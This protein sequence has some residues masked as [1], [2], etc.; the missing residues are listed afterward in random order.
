MEQYSRVTRSGQEVRG[1]LVEVV[2][3][4]ALTYTLG[5]SC[6]LGI[7]TYVDGRFNDISR[8]NN[9]EDLVPTIP[10]EDWGFKHPTGEIHITGRIQ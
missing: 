5:D 8:I 7:I 9:K 3:S 2:W 10:L 6:K 1:E 4:R